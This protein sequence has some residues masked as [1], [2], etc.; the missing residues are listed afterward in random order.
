MAKSTTPHVNALRGPSRWVPVPGHDLATGRWLT[1]GQCASLPQRRRLLALSLIAAAPTCVLLTA[2]SP[3][4]A[5]AA[6]EAAVQ[7][8]TETTAL[9]LGLS[10]DE[11]QRQRIRQ[12]V[13]GYWQRRQRREMDAVMGATDFLARLRQTEPALREVGLRMSRPAAL[14]NL[15][16]EAEA[17]DVLA[18]WLL[19]QYHQKHPP[20]APGHRGGLPLT[21]DSTDG[22]LDLAHFMATEV[23]RQAARVPN[24]AER[25]QAVRAAVARHASLDAEAQFALA[26]APGEAARLRFAWARSQ[27]LDRLLMRAEL[28]GPL[29]AAEQAQ[30]RQFMA[31]IHAQLQGLAAQGQNLLG[32]SL[33]AIRQNSETLMGRGTVWNPAANRWEQQ[34][35]IVTEFNGTVRVP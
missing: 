13:E 16:V 34:G 17:G 12:F 2:P 10:F 31:G 21:R 3:A 1:A 35:G 23:H 11:G 28:G 26:Q 22:Q 20:L 15:E 6:P 18:A 29:S 30:V 8:F 33:A 4:Q 25:E 14:R 7:A 24:A 32:S 27:P 5:Q 9:L 19:V